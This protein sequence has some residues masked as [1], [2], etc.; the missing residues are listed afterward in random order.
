[1]LNLDQYCST[2]YTKRPASRQQRTR[3]RSTLINYFHFVFL[4][5]LDIPSN[6]T[7]ATK[8]ETQNVEIQT[9]SSTLKTRLKERTQSVSD[10]KEI[11][12]SKHYLPK[13]EYSKIKS[14]LT[15]A[16]FEEWYFHKLKESEEKKRMEI[17]KQEEELI[18]KETKK[19]EMKEKATEDFKNWLKGKQEQMKKA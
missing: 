9:K 8:V 13:E 1:M 15:N 17:E 6:R 4:L 2:E 5:G 3:S 11:V 19:V 18:E 14:K 16:V 7:E 10:L 12:D